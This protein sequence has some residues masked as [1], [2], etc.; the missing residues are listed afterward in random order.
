MR[1]VVALLSVVAAAFALVLDD[2]EALFTR[3][4]RRS[5]VATSHNR[6]PRGDGDCGFYVNADGE[7]RYLV[8]VASSPAPGRMLSLWLANTNVRLVIEADARVLVDVDTATF[9][10]GHVDGFRMGYKPSLQYGCLG[11]RRIEFTT[12]FRVW[13]YAREHADEHRTHRVLYYQVAYELDAVGD[14]RE[15]PGPSTSPLREAHSFSLDGNACTPPVLVAQSSVVRAF[16]VTT[17]ASPRVRV[18]VDDETTIDAPLATLVPPGVDLDVMRG[19]ATSAELHLPMPFGRSFR[20]CA[21][22]CATVAFDVS[23][24]SRE[25]EWAPLR[26][27]LAGGPSRVD[28]DLVALDVD[29]GWG[30][31]VALDLSV[32]QTHHVPSA[33]PCLGS[34]MVFEGDPRIVVD[35]RTRASFHGSGHEDL[36]GYAHGFPQ[37]RAAPSESQAC[38]HYSFAPGWTRPSYRALRSWTRDSFAFDD[39]ARVTLAHGDGVEKHNRVNCTFSTVLWLYGSLAQRDWVAAVPVRRDN[40]T[41]FLVPGERVRYLA[42]NRRFDARRSVQRAR[43]LVNDELLGVWRNEHCDRFNVESDD[44][45]LVRVQPH[46][47]WPLA[48]R[49]EPVPCNAFDDDTTWSP[50][51]C[52]HPDAVDYVRPEQ[53]CSRACAPWSV[54]EYTFFARF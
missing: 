17:T 21:S 3:R 13:V 33:V 19:T 51:P 45:F 46:W 40:D 31:L 54:F 24:M 12:S 50:E 2:D 11:Y 35:R 10:D 32:E 7:R 15:S 44:R 42:I 8:D 22:A 28:E 14:D 4:P 9:C 18:V 6:E 37:G 34:P 20:V 5:F 25:R 48:V 36:F 27:V 38:L 16:R 30:N 39:G 47:R 1:I 43:V 29:G 53:L 23:P 49:I 41:T 26:A 52:P